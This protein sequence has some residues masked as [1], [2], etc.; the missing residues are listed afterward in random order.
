MG[1]SGSG[2]AF[3]AA[4][5]LVAMTACRGAPASK[6]P[7][8]SG[9]PCETSPADDACDVCT[10]ARCCPE[11]T[12][13]MADSSCKSADDSLDACEAKAQKA[14]RGPAE[15]YASFGAAGPLAKKRA[16]CIH[17]SCARECL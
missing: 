3:L 13:C 8:A 2:A 10:A 15:C 16:D 1:E 17:G 6:P 9:G 7:S 5:A 4:L 12:A 14:G 11:E